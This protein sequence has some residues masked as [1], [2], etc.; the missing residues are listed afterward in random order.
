M[1]FAL[2]TTFAIVL[3]LFGQSQAYAVVNSSPINPSAGAAANWHY[4]P[5]GGATV[6]WT[7][8]AGAA[9]APRVVTY[10]QRRSLLGNLPRAVVQTAG[11]VV[12]G[13]ADVVKGV[14]GGVLNA[15]GG[16]AGG[17]L[18]TAG[19]VVGGAAN[20]VNGVAGG[21][22]NT[23]GGLAGGVLQTAGGLVDGTTK[24]AKGVVGGVGSLLG[25]GNARYNT[26]Y[27]TY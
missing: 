4:T 7:A 19:G 27:Y 13:A 18:Q 16:L 20:V 10:E 14:A 17:V 24:L 11:G 22:L 8:N 5:N 21:V 25:G 26:H 3:A 15:A 23:A 12:G 6:T 9:S 2:G 1:K